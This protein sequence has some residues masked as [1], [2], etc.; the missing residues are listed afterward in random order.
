MNTVY[1]CLLL[2]LRGVSA[3]E[4]KRESLS[5]RLIVAFRGSDLVTSASDLVIVATLLHTS[6]NDCFQ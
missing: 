6:I 2:I 3:S 1:W 5:I 4:G